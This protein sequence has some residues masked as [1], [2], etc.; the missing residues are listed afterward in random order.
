MLQ[1]SSWV[2]NNKPEFWEIIAK[3]RVELPVGKRFGKTLKNKRRDYGA[4]SRDI[5]FIMQGVGQ[6]VI[7]HDAGELVYRDII[8]TIDLLRNNINEIDSRVSGGIYALEATNKLVIASN[9]RL[10]TRQTYFTTVNLSQ[11]VI[12]KMHDLHLKNESKVTLSEWLF[13][14]IK[15]YAKTNEVNL[16]DALIVIEFGGK[17]G[18]PHLHVLSSMNKEQAS[19]VFKKIAAKDNNSI[20]TDLV[21][22][23]FG[24]IRGYPLKEFAYHRKLTDIPSIKSSVLGSESGSRI[25]LNNLGKRYFIGKTLNEEAKTFF[26]FIKNECVPVLSKPYKAGDLTERQEA[27]RSIHNER[28]V[29]DV[30]AWLDEMSDGESPC[31]YDV[32]FMPHED[33]FYR[34]F[35]SN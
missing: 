11:K 15:R 21:T 8:Q 22:D 10:L 35:R 26:D 13:S 29:E 6:F 4:G 27:S 33:S 7:E 1:Q 2:V 20:K 32:Y 28:E 9:L 31:S 34:G 16:D 5:P 25:K 18:K 3:K 19:F 24:S 17:A 23:P 30:L 14:T 12:D